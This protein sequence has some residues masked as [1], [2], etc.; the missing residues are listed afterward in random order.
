[1]IIGPEMRSCLMCIT[2]ACEELLGMYARRSPSPLQFSDKIN[3]PNLVIY[4]ISCFLF[5]LIHVEKK[6]LSHISIW[7]LSYYWLHWE[8]SFEN[9][10][11][12]FETTTF[13]KGSTESPVQK[14]RGN[15]MFYPGLSSGYKKRQLLWWEITDL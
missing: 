8:E 7:S 1:M 13:S 15:A 9:L 11:W 6:Q 5:A 3:K 12:Y 14:R 4:T 2:F 10:K